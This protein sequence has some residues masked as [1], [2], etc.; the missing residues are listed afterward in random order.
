MISSKEL[1]ARTGLSRATLNNYIRLGLLPRPEVRTGEEASDGAARLGYFPDSAVERIAEIKSLRQQGI[2]MDR[3]IE[4]LEPEQGV[5]QS[6]AQNAPL[7][8]LEAKPNVRAS[9]ADVLPNLTIESDASPAYLVNNRLELIWWNEHAARE[10][11]GSPEQ[12]PEE[13]EKRGLFAM[14]LP[15]ISAVLEKREYEEVLS[16]QLAAAKRRLSDTQL[17]NCFDGLASELRY[18]A[19]EVLGEVEEVG[20]GPVLHFGVDVSL[21]SSDFIYTDLYTSYFREGILFTFDHARDAGS[22]IHGRL[23]QRGS[24]ISQLMRN[25]K[26]HVTPLVV[27]VADLQDSVN[28]CS[29][30]P[31]EE[32]FEL[33]NQVWQEA[34]PILKQYRG[35]HGKHAGDGMVYYFFPQ[36][37]EDYKLNALRCSLELKQMMRRLT[38]KWQQR[39]GWFND[40]CLNIGLHE[41][42]EWFG[43]YHAGSH[44]EFTV[45]GDTVNYAARLSNFATNGSIYATKAL[46]NSIPATERKR[47]HYGVYRSNDRAEKQLV[48]NSYASIRN[49][50]PELCQINGQYRDIEMLPI[51]EV[52]DVEDLMAGASAHG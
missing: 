35:S 29:E 18:H 48:V 24:L 22:A 13:L 44:V 2:S 20:G 9:T 11:F 15:Y 30:L 28:I 33:I 34:E 16:L 10:L 39:K 14:M 12:M 46:I 40:L 19:E 23:A 37:D 1:I 36:P 32:Y 52:L 3:M 45:L 41:G 4:H 8:L 42:R 7:R 43:A 17:L 38:Q 27:M 31:A 21:G 51:T 49:L 25:R 5:E 50:A 6:S 26:P 47:I